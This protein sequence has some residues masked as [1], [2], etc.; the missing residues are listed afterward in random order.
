[1]VSQDTTHIFMEKATR[2]GKLLA[3]ASNQKISDI[4]AWLDEA[5]E[6]Q[7]SVELLKQ[8]RLGIVV[9]KL[10]SHSD[11]A[12][13]KRA[14]LLVDKWKDNLTAKTKEGEEGS[15]P[16]QK[17]QRV[18]SPTGDSTRDK[19]VQM[20]HSALMTG[21]EEKPGATREHDDEMAMDIAMVA[22]RLLFSEFNQVSGEYRAKFRSK[23]L[24]LKENNP[25][26][27]RSLLDGALTPERFIKMT[28]EE[29]ASEEQKRADAAIHKDNLQKSQAA[30]D[31]AAET[32]MF[33]CGKCKQRK[34][35][36]FQMQTRSADEPMT[37]YVTCMNCNNRWKC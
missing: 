10:K 21:I 7:V 15:T 20:F 3:D 24:N 8:S 12:V 22:E 26:L 37:T 1:M 25:H 35:K 33:Q 6:L 4:E 9:N 14:A 16:P 32:D 18:S 29:M 23:Y 13:R 11:Q 27:R 36:Y 17:K 31:N 28:T 5:L 19:C 2:L 30:R 34:C